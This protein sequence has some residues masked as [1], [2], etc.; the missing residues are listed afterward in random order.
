MAVGFGSVGIEWC[1]MLE[2]ML[3]QDFQ[4]IQKLEVKFDNELTTIIGP[5]DA[6][7]SACLRAFRWVAENKAFDRIIRD[8]ATQARVEVWIDGRSVVRQRSKSDNLYFLDGVEFRAFGVNVPDEIAQ[9][10]RVGDQNFQGQHDTVFWLQ[11]SAGEVSRK[12]NALVDLSV[13]DRA[14]SG[15]LNR[16][17]QCQSFVQAYRE[18][19]DK[20]KVKRDELRWVIEAEKKLNDLLEAKQKRDAVCDRVTDLEY[21][22]Q[23]IKRRDEAKTKTIDFVRRIRVVGETAQKLIKVREDSSRLA[24][25]VT[26][27]KRGLVLGQQKIPDFNRLDEVY[28]QSKAASEMRQQ[29]QATLIKLRG[30]LERYRVKKIQLLELENELDKVS[31]EGCPLCGQPIPCEQEGVVCG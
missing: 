28:R 14:T 7:K 2:R 26:I 8:G 22:I 10:F 27:I 13:M 1:V 12:L 3:I 9:L 20:A 24:S 31:S 23:D 16:L 25:R 29:L 11:D 18:M 4:G 17:R 19:V 21:R 6:G 30:T 5:S 15:I